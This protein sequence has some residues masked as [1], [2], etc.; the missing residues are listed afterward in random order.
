MCTAQSKRNLVTTQFQLLNANAK[1]NAGRENKAEKR[2][3]VWQSQEVKKKNNNNNKD[4]R[5]G[6]EYLE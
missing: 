5:G 2:M 6:V 3:F 4:S 1:P